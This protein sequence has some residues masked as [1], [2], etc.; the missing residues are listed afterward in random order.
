[1]L[2]EQLGTNLINNYLTLEIFGLFYNKALL[3][4]PSTLDLTSTLS[5]F[6]LLHQVSFL[7]VTLSISLKIPILKLMC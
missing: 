2:Y 4:P 7:S 6:L 3:R 1:M 5:V